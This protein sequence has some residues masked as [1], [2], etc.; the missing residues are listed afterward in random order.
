MEGEAGRPVTTPQQA[1]IA[2]L[3]SRLACAVEATYWDRPY[4]E[5]IAAVRGMGDLTT[6]GLQPQP[7]VLVEHLAEIARERAKVRAGQY[8]PSHDVIHG[9][10]NLAQLAGWRLAM[11]AG[12]GADRLDDAR[13]TWVEVGQF[14]L[15][16]LELIDGNGDDQ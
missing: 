1:E 9:Y 12:V 10:D 4:D 16:A 14:V 2:D 11:L 5:R 7:T 8:G 15:A 3:R 6:N 13:R